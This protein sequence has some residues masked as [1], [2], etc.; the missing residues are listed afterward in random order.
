MGRRP[1]SFLALLLLACLTSAG[2]SFSGNSPQKASTKKPKQEDDSIAHYNKWLNEDVLYIISPEEKAVFKQLKTDEEKEQFIEHFWE[3][4]NPD[5]HSG[6]NS[7]K[8]EHYQRLAYA[9]EHFASGVPGWKTDRGRVWIM[10]GKPDEIESHPSGGSYQ[11]EIYEGGGETSTYPF[12]RWRYRHIDGIGDDVEIEFVDTTMSGEYHISMDPDEKD[13][14]LMVPGA[15]LTLNEQM[16]LTTKDQRPYFN[17]SSA[18]D[19]T[20]NGF[21]RA[22]DMPFARMEQYFALQRPPQIKFE[23]LKGMVTTHITY[24]TLPYALRMDFVRL[25]PE[26]VLV[27][28]TIELSNKDLEFKKELEF[29]R[30]SVNVYGVVSSIS[31]KVAA[32][33]EDTISTEYT[34][35]DF[36]AGKNARSEYQKIVALPPGQR[37]KLDLVLKDINAGTMG[38]ISRGIAVPKYDG[39]QLE[40]SSVI[41]ANYITPVP[42]TSNQLDRY[43]IG[44]QKI[45]PNVKSEYYPGQNLLSYVQVYNATID[46]TTLTPS[47]EVIYSIKTSEGKVMEQLQDLAGK[48]VQFFSGQRVV[49]IKQ[50]TLK[51]L[52]P[53]KYTLAIKVTDLISKQ[54]VDCQTDFKVVEAVNQPVA[55][56]K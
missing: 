20:Y 36:A 32:E 5:P 35:A 50:T 16:G 40:A 33:F 46:Q 4:R 8:E 53:G 54:T 47:V 17:P 41:L 18:N 55:A 3:R 37:Y 14:L 45:Q 26:K 12:E 39:A 15:G 29:N 1:V 24:N 38:V 27:P 9:N 56:I 11:R 22:K 30:A 51:D 42:E 48:S 13:A 44:D 21:M 25:S 7:Y 19:P 43:V 31:G 52:A 6:D 34:D 10:Y 49:L 28:V 23:D 2:Y